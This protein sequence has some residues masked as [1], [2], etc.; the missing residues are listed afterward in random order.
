MGTSV[1]LVFLAPLMALYAAVENAFSLLGFDFFEKLS[2]WTAENSDK[3]IEFQIKGM[4]V[5]QFVFGTF[6]SMIFD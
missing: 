1:L 2:Q 6:Y 4:Y 5:L 3:I